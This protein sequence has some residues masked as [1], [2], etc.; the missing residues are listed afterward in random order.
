MENLLFKI[1]RSVIITLGIAGICCLVMLLLGKYSPETTKLILSL[2]GL[3]TFPIVLGNLLFSNPTSS[4]NDPVK[5]TLFS[6]IIKSVGLS[7][8]ILFAANFILWVLVWG[9]PIGDLFTERNTVFYLI[10][11]CILIVTS[12]LFHVISNQ[13]QSKRIV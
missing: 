12:I 5:S 6:Q 13:I 2:N 9:A 4:N 10:G 3:Y 8:A 1:S 7:M 11:F